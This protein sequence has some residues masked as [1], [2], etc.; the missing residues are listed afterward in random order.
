MATKKQTVSAETQRL[1][2]EVKRCRESL[3]YFCTT[4]CKILASSDKAG[5][6]INFAL[7]PAQE[8]VAAELEAHKETIALKARQLGQSWLVVAFA[9]R[10]MLF[11]P[12]Q[13]VLMFSK[14]DD[15]AAELIFRLREMYLRLPEW[16]QTVGVTTDNDH[17]FAFGNGSRALAHATT[18]GR[19]Y[20]ASLAILDESDHVPDLQKMLNAIQPTVDAGGRLILLSTVDKSEPES[21]FK[22]IWRA[23]RTG[24]NGF[25][26]IFLPWSAAPWRTS[27]WY[28]AKKKSTLSNTGSL[29]A[30]WQEFPATEHEALAPRQLDKRLAAQWLLQVYQEAKP[31][32]PAGNYAPALRLPAI[33]G[34]CVYA[35]PEPGHIYVIGGDPAEGN[36]TSDDSALAVLDAASGEE[37][38]TLAGKF[39]PTVFA[40]Y[41]RQ[42]AEWYN[43]AAILCERNNHGHAVIAALDG[44]GLASSLLGGHDGKVGWM[45]SMLGKVR[46]YDCCA[47]ACRNGE[48]TIRDFGT[49]TQLASIDGSTLRAPEEG[50][51][52]D[53]R[54]DAFALACAARLQVQTAVADDHY[55]PRASRGFGTVESGYYGS[56]YR[57]AEEGPAP[58]GYD[59]SLYGQ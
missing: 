15:E 25:H 3:A 21:A 27:E 41:A 43:G 6:W 51:Q 54:A 52:H 31:I 23:A 55:E 28:E 53:D 5:A 12:V 9:L 39:E 33:P 48:V 22:K 56:R 4:Y 32:D 8:Q 49:Y 17:E 11:N 50:G 35:R 57:E 38:A 44:A 40:D 46:L 2:L 30:L 7:W 47:D 16:M 58:Q 20:T 18:G 59:G 1:L 37:V 10:E 14:R 24:E 34:L 42:L 13:T 19:S 45:S 26:P 29:D 36:P